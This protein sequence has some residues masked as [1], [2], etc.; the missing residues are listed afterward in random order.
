MLYSDVN[1]HRAIRDGDLV[2]E[3][4]VPG[5]V[6]PASVDCHLSDRPL[7]VWRNG[8][9]V[10]IET[11]MLGAFDSNVRARPIVPW[12]DQ[13]DEMEEVGLGRHRFG[14][15]AGDIVDGVFKLAPGQFALASTIERF[16]IGHKVAG[17]LEGKSSLARLGLIVHT[18]AG[19]FDP[20]FR[21][22]ATLELLNVSPRPI[23]LRPN[24]PIAQM[25]FFQ[26]LSTPDHLYNG[27][28]QDQ[29]KDPEASHYNRNFG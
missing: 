18:T 10:R 19:F 11:G 12:L 24:M 25:A 1:V 15:R 16:E 13:A 4:L 5:A 8:G 23:L 9:M 28:Y 14:P 26:M 6:Q 27:K 20:G 22:Y 3:G 29:G 17:R 2:I 7:K 21:G